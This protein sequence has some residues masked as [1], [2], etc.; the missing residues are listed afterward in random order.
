MFD[1]CA[2]A[3]CLETSGPET[4]WQG[5]PTRSP[6]RSPTRSRR[7]WRP[8][9]LRDATGYDAPGIAAVHAASWRS[10]YR[11]I[12]PDA[13][14]DGPLI[15]DRERHWEAK[16]AGRRPQDI[17]LLAEDDAGR[18]VGFLAI[19]VLH[20]ADGGAYLDNLHL[21]PERRGERLGLRLLDRALPQVRAAGAR[22]GFLWVLD[23]N[24]PA[25]RFYEGLGARRDR[26]DIRVMGGVPVGHTRY[27]W[28]DLATLAATCR[29]RLSIAS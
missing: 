2:A 8:A 25:I 28:D 4:L 12:A 20:R 11:G 21:L 9:R 19:W 15:A 26:H 24:Q 22:T 10:A 18:S 14:L 16:L 1:R 7:S 29:G 3:V 23:D 6:M 13:L 27:V 17:V 5:V